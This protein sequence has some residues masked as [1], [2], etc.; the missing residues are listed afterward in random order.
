MANPAGKDQG[1]EWIELVNKSKSTIDLSGYQLQNTKKQNLSGNIPPNSVFLIEK[2]KISVRN[3]NE[4]IRLIGSSGEIIDTVSYK[5]APEGLSFG[6]VTI[7]NNQK[8]KTD[9]TWGTP[10]KNQPNQTLYEIKASILSPPQIGTDFYFE[11]LDGDQKRKVIFDEPQFKFEDLS[12]LLTSNTEAYFLLEKSGP[13]FILQD[14]Q[15]IQ[16]QAQPKTKA[17]EKSPTNLMIIIAIISFI[18][19]YILYSKS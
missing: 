7:R 19:L 12:S 17:K 10:T 18:P 16:V 13:D 4:E 2:P 11:I 9:W 1:N 5:S 6:R 14:F 8:S 15:I 3:S